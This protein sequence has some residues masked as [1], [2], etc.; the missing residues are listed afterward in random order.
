MRPLEKMHLRVLHSHWPLGAVSA[1]PRQTKRRLAAPLCANNSR[2]LQQSSLVKRVGI[3]LLHLQVSAVGVY[4]Q[5]SAI[6]PGLDHSKRSPTEP[7]E[8]TSFLIPLFIG[9]AGPSLDLKESHESV[10][11]T[12][13]S[14][15]RD[16]FPNAPTGSR[17]VDVLLGHFRRR[18]KDADDRSHRLNKRAGKIRRTMMR[19]LEHLRLQVDFPAIM[20]TSKERPASSFRSPENR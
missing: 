11:R 8:L 14:G 7:K 12:N 1:S 2:R 6:G 5:T 17:G 20:L 10:T 15:T 16:H 3:G 9:D 18:W 19:H 13:G 4:E